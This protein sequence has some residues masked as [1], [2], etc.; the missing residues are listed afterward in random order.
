MSVKKNFTVYPIQN[1]RLWSLYKKQQSSFWRAEEVDLSGDMRDWE[2]LNENEQYFIK[3]ILAFFA[4]S[5]GIVNWNISDRFKE[6]IKQLE[7]LYKET[8]YLYNYQAMIEDVHNE[9][10]SLM[11]DTYIKSS[12]EKEHL[13][14]AIETIPCVKKKAEWAMKWILDENS[15]FSQ[16]L[17]AFAIVEGIF[18][19]GSFCAIYWLKKRGLMT[20]LTSANEFI[21][22]DEGMHTETACVLYSLLE[23]K[24][25]EKTI[26]Q[27]VTD[28]LTIEKEFITES[29]PCDLI[30]MNS[31]TMCQYIEF[32]ADNLLVNLGCSK[33]HN[34][35]FPSTFS[36]MDAISIQGKTN[37]FEKRPTEYQ[38]TSIGAINL[39]DDF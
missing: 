31:P 33:I 29:I 13:F 18:F 17:V 28:A 4:G 16:R 5:D 19:S 9:M 2:K 11:L 27:M 32:V 26:H 8:S 14:N 36:F 7:G 37:F 39:V 20:G 12:E 23:D 10:Y 25:S 34:V 24:V 22:R 1:Q 35:E 3:N 6:D 30:G 38:K 21:A 15:S